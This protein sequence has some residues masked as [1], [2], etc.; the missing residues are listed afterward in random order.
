MIH[1]VL[2]D[3]FLLGSHLVLLIADRIIVHLHHEQNGFVITLNPFHVI[4]PTIIIEKDRIF[5]DRAFLA[6]VGL[7][8]FVGFPNHLVEDDFHFRWEHQIGPRDFLSRFIGIDDEN[9]WV[10]L[11]VFFAPSGFP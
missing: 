7:K 9:V 5:N 10:L 2:G 3:P 6:F 8:D 11:L 4:F 1:H